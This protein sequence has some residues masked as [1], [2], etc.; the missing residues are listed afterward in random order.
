MN[1]LPTARWS[2]PLCSSDWDI[3]PRA[4]QSSQHQ[5]RTKL[6]LLI[7]FI[8]GI[9]YIVSNHVRNLLFLHL[10][11]KSRISRCFDR[12]LW[13]GAEMAAN[14]LSV[15]FPSVHRHVMTAP[16]PSLLIAPASA[17]L[18]YVTLV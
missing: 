18:S 10:M 16:Q 17:L 6:V 13:H 5:G 1:P 14:P 2:F 9:E 15:V 11:P 4:K 8:F 7:F 12:S 3:V